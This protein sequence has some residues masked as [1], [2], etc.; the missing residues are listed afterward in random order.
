MISTSLDWE[1]KRVVLKQQIQSL[2]YNKDLR[3]MLK[4]IDSM[5][6]LLS[7][8]EVEARRNHKDS[9]KLK[10]LNDV[11]KSIETLEQWIIMGTL[12]S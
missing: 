3:T 12:L 1:Q 11:N 4:N 2:P 7:K 6:I 10:E 9:S 5:V 8:A